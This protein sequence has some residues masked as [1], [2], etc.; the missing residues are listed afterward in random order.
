MDFRPCRGRQFVGLPAQVPVR[1]PQRGACGRL[2]PPARGQTGW[3]WGISRRGRGVRF[4]APAA[5]A[6]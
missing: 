4:S 1:R 3:Q 6:R 2:P 5:G